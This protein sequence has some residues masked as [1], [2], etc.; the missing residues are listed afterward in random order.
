MDVDV[1]GWVYSPQRGPTTRRQRLF[2]GL[3]RQMCG[4]PAPAATQSGSADNSKTSSRASS[5][6]RNA[7]AEEDLIN[8]EAENILKRGMAETERAERGSY[9][10]NPSRRQYSPSIQSRNSSPD[11]GRQGSR[12]SQAT[13]LS[14]DDYTPLQKRSSWPQPTKMTAAELAVANAHLLARLK[15]FMSNPLALSLIHI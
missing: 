4:L 11:R 9:S 14:P 13:T 12:L 15:P 1:R 6:D 8:L 3:A 10:E 2:I 5:P 7:R